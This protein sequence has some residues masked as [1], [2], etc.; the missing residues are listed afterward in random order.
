MRKFSIAFLGIFLLCLQTISFGQET[1]VIEADQMNSG[2]VDDL[3]NKISTIDSVQQENS[4]KKGIYIAEKLEYHEGVKQCH[5]LLNNL[6]A[7]QENY[8][9]ELRLLLL[10]STYLEKYNLMESQKLNYFEI[11]DIYFLFDLFEKAKNNYKNALEV[12]IEFEPE[13]DLR[14]HKQLSLSYYKLR[15]FESATAELNKLTSK[16]RLYKDWSSVLWSKQLKAKIAHAK[17]YFEA[18]LTIN[19]AIIELTDSLNLKK[20]KGIAI[21]NLAYTYKYLDDYKSA[22]TYLSGILSKDDSQLDAV[23]Y[24]NLAILSQNNQEYTDAK[25]YFN[26]ALEI[27]E[28]NKNYRSQAYVLDILTLLYYQESDFHNAQKY[29]S[30]CMVLSESHKLGDIYMAAYYSQSIIN[31]GLYEYE[32]ALT[33]M[34]K[35]LYIKDS[36]ESIHNSE[37]GIIELQQLFLDQAESEIQLKVIGEEVKD[38]EIKRLQAERLATEEQLKRFKSDSL[39]SEQE[40]ITQLLKIKEIENLLSIQHQSTEIQLLGEQKKQQTLDLKLEQAKRIEKEK[41]LLLVTKDNEI[42]G[43][44][45]KERQAYLNRLIYF[46]F[47]LL[48]FIIVIIIF[49]INVRKKNK[50]IEAQRVLIG[51]EKEKADA[52]LLNILPVTVAEELKNKGKSPP[53][54]LEMISIV[55]T[56]FAGFTAISE[57]LTPVQLVEKLDELFLEFDL[58]VEKNGLTRIKTI[59]DAY[60]CAAGIPDFDAN[61]A[62]NAVQTAIE[63]RDFIE[64]FNLSLSEEEPKWNIRI[65]INSGS[66]VAGVVGIKKFAY[67]IWGDSVNVASRME[68]SGKINKVNISDTTFQIVKGKFSTEHRGKVYAKNKG[69]IDM[70]FVEPNPK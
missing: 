68:S 33:S 38:L 37:Q 4:L 22:E 45:L 60:M 1:I 17:G 27:Y 26:E 54:H 48:I 28:L 3:L 32:D 11:G 52:L 51:V 47:G 18:E 64:R 44:E 35:H 50:K 59:G 15:E 66:V 20:E 23:I 8:A 57:R 16:G 19:K 6:Y 21:N 2:Y 53:R 7:A 12:K 30:Q 36:L 65:G 34:N 61:H 63:M 24:Q 9:L 13:R 40:L 29:N 49:Y 31:Q 46:S 56:D 5:F 43:F 41:D 58:I 39:F 62:E 55:F 10:Y 25:F 14:L 42:L 69:E 67:D 70:Y